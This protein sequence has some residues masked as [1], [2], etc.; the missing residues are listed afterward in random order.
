MCKNASVVTITNLSIDTDHKNP[1]NVYLRS[2]VVVAKHALKLDGTSSRSYNQGNL[3]RRFYTTK[4]LRGAPT[5][6]KTTASSSGKRVFFTKEDTALPLPNLIAHQKD[7]WREFV[8]T[9]LSE[10]FAELNPIEDYTGQKL[11]LRF[12]KY[13]FQD[14]KTTEKDAKENNITF[15]APLHATVELTNKVTGEVKEQEIYL[16]DYPWMTERGTFVIN[17]TERVVVSQLIRSCWCVLY[18]R[19]QRRPQPL[20]CK[21]YSWPWCMARI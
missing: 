3:R 5:R 7:S 13:E 6:G 20:R 19:H 18:C 21:A 11:E 14:P 9:G 2:S 10:I 16:G 12:K 15:D 8:E 1:H 17:G 4:Q